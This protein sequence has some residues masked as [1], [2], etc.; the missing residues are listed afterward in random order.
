MGKMN[1]TFSEPGLSKGRQKDPFELN[2]NEA[3]SENEI[4]FNHLVYE[5][6]EKIYGLFR[7][8]VSS[9]D[10]ADDLTQ[11]TFI[12]VYKN[13]P[14]FKQQ[15]SIYTWI[16]R[17][18][19]NTGLNYLRRQKLRQGLGIE[20][21][22]HWFSASI[23]PENEQRNSVLRQAIAKLPPKQ[24]MVVMLRS[25]QEL[26]FR[27]VAAIMESTENSAKVNYSHALGNLRQILAGMGVDYAAL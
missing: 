25:F 11:E 26:S 17:I 7:R 3:K 2:R 8:M 13:L 6:H 18:A 15:S 1:L 9:H 14:Q 23:E 27:E 19:M 20:K 5:N 12:K 22:E 16:Y 21:I 24:Q 4:R 10:E